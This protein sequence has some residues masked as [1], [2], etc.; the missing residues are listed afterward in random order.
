[1]EDSEVNQTASNSV[2]ILFDVPARSIAAEMTEAATLSSRRQL[3]A[4][5]KSSPSP[6]R[7]A[8]I[9]EPGRALALPGSELDRVYPGRR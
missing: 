3:A 8:R 2:R 9:K 6:L 4:I 5:L 1:M 7:P